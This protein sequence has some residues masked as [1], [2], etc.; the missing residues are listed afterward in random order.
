MSS[1]TLLSKA[2]W[3]FSISLKTK[4]LSGKCL[5]YL[6]IIFEFTDWGSQKQKCS[7]QIKELAPHANL[8]HFVLYSLFR[9]RSLHSYLASVG[10]YSINFYFGRK[11]DKHASHS[12]FKKSVILQYRAVMLCSWRLKSYG[13]RA[14]KSSVLY[15]S[16][17]QSERKC[18]LRCLQA[19]NQ[20]ELPFYLTSVCDTDV[21]GRNVFFPSAFE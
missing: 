9:P 15:I 4:N 13:G 11:S 19:H 21:V 18:N 5:F 2:F 20:I 16:A 17:V 1:Q 6:F 7:L 8:M 10:N 12:Q 14:V 3:L